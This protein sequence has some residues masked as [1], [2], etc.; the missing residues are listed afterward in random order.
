MVKALKH[1][2]L[3]VAGLGFLSCA[4]APQHVEPNGH[5]VPCTKVAGIPGPVDLLF[6]RWHPS[7]R[8]LV[9]SY[10][11]WGKADEGAIYAI[12]LVTDTRS[13]TFARIGEPPAGEPGHFA[14]RPDG[15]DLWKS[16]KGEILLAVAVHG[17]DQGRN[18]AVVLYRVKGQT[19]QYVDAI[20]DHKWIVDPKDV[21]FAP[22]GK[23]YVT[24]FSEGGHS[25]WT[26]VF[27]RPPSTLVQC[28]P[29]KKERRCTVMA[30]NIGGGNG[31]VV[32][33]G[34]PM[35]VSFYGGYLF[36]VDRSKLDGQIFLRRFARVPY[37]DN[38]TLASDLTILV[39]SHAMPAVALHAQMKANAP[40]AIYRLDPAADSPAPA[41]LFQDSGETIQAASSAIWYGKKLYLGQMFG[42]GV[43]VVP[44]PNT[45]LDDVLR[46][47]RSSG[48]DTKSLVENSDGTTRS[49]ATP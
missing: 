42:D 41:L 27:N 28:D 29:A 49:A 32:R 20:R 38:M 30:R 2:A 12:D 19:L 22:D 21:A 8:L 35:A 23:L 11:R 7:P 36:D 37:P 40:S 16:P 1:I 14:F 6:D 5:I 15:I 18:E 44:I 47:E 39:A 13:E 34:V 33:N 43:V 45:G 9:S 31:V 46:C 48:L 4:A 3:A 26:Y 25:R 24:N 17:A 10:D